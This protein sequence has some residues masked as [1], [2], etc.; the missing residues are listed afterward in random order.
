VLRQFIDKAFLS[1]FEIVEWL[2]GSKVNTVNENF[3]SLHRAVPLHVPLN[4]RVVFCQLYLHRARKFLDYFP[5][6]KVGLSNH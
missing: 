5:K 3:I 2:E 6:M 1:T 4:T